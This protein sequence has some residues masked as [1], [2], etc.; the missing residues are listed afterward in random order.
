YKGAT[1]LS[2]AA[3]TVAVDGTRAA[4]ISAATTGD[5][6]DLIDVTTATSPR[7]VRSI[8]LGPPG[9]AKGIEVVGTRAYVAANSKR[10]IIY[11]ITTPSAVTQLGAGFTVGSALDVKVVGGTVYVADWPATLDILSMP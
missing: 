5:Y 7:T 10:L 11:D 3:L 1:L 6:M 4:A 9:T 8:L 2:G